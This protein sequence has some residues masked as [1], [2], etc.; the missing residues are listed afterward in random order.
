MR[1]ALVVLSGG[2]DS[3]TCAAWAKQWFP[4]G[5]QCL[6]FDY[7][8]RHRRELEAAKRIAN[9]FG[10][11]HEILPMPALAGGPT[12]ALTNAELVVSETDPATGLPRS[13]VPG[14]N[15]VF[16][17]AAAAYAMARGIYNV[18]TGVCQTDYSGYP[19]CRRNTILALEHAIGLGT[20]G[21]PLLSIHT[22]L[23]HLTKAQTV[24][25]ASELPL[26]WQAVAMSWTCYE[27]GERPCGK[28]PACVLRAKG[29]ADAGMDDPALAHYSEV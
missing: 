16:L 3:A 28:C 6:S 29:F 4:E 14:R 23:M 27:G 10:A 22:P 9:L 26:G 25:M 8:Q 20:E 19:D 7:G 18:V 13:F 24:K 15:L 5:F 12:S 17:T 2:Q 11:Q 21:L 1:K